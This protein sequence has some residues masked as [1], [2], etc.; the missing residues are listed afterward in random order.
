MN[1]I[2]VVAC[3]WLFDNTLLGVTE[4]SGSLFVCLLLETALVLL[5]VTC[6]EGV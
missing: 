4:C 3:N 2:T 5:D 1:E 6:G